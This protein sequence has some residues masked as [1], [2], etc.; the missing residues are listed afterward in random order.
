MN[1]APSKQVARSKVIDLSANRRRRPV[2]SQ[3]EWVRR[4][5][6]ACRLVG[7]PEVLHG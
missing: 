7:A 6:E 1:P 5:V 4:K 3:V 2:R